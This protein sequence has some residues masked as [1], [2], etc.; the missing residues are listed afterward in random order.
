MQQAFN[1]LLI[2]MA[3]LAVVVFIALFFVDAGYG[4][5]LN[6][7]WG[8][9]VSNKVGWFVMESP[10]FLL[11]TVLWL[12]SDRRFEAAPLCFLFLFQLHYFQRA[13]IFPFLLKGRGRMPL[14][15]IAMGILFNMVNAVMQG[16][17]IFY[18]APEGLYTSA[19]LKTP[20]FIVGTA[21]FIAGMVINIHSEPYHPE[22]PPPR[23]Y[24]SPYPLRRN[25]PLGEFG[26]LFRRVRGVGRVRGTHMVVVGGGIRPVD[27]RQ[28]RAPRRLPA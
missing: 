15:I 2:V 9:T 27:V 28:P 4:M 6:R 11:M 20:Q 8:K 23:R 14:A 26:Q 19:W 22:P 5:L 21:V 7:K 3:V 10:V 12:M 24:G 18:L 1:I 13:F 25:V 16:G 17:W